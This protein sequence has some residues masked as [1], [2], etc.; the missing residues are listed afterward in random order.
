MIKALG[1]FGYQIA[2]LGRDRYKTAIP[3][4]LSRLSA[5]LP[6]DTQT[7]SLAEALSKAEILT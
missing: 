3:R 6:G 1:T 5:V 4:T 2:I 7:E